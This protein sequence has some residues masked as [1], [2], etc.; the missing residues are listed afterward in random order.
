[1]NLHEQS[2]LAKKAA[3]QLRS[4]TYAQRRSILHDFADLLLRNTEAILKANETDIETGEKSGIRPSMID[5]LRLNEAR[6]EAAAEGIRQLASLPDPLGIVLDERTLTSGVHLK[7]ITVPIGVIGIIYESRPNV[8]ADCAALCIMSGNACVLKGGREAWHSSSAIAA[9]MKQALQKNGISPDAVMLADPVSHEEPAAFMNDRENID[10]LIPRGSSRLIQ[11]VVQHARVPVIETGAG[12]CHTYVE[13][14]ADPDMAERIL[15]N[16]KCSRPSVCNAMETMLLEEACAES[17]LPRIVRTMKENG[18]T[19]YGD[20]HTC[21]ICS[22]VLPAQEDSFDTEYN[23]LILNIAVVKDV[24]EAIAHIEKHGTHH[25]D[26]ILTEDAEHALLF[27][28]S[29]DSACVYHN[30]STRFTDGFE[31]GLGAEIGI[32]T[33]KLHARGP[34]GL[35]ALTTYTYHLE[36]K[37]EIR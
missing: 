20:E 10:L 27:L 22:D 19:M 15:I 23:D 2:I 33:Q 24:H 16:A 29:V 28:N 35:Q 5:R 25:S 26:A 18:V 21:R 36:G 11:A 14:S 7:K 4:L 8:T 31:F 37:G 1:M 6:I 12:I 17:F 30:A 9:C 3:P 34:M 32:S 13:A